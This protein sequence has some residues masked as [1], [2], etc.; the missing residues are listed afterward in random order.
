M[1]LLN[2]SPSASVDTTP[3]KLWYGKRP[4]LSNLKLFGSLAYAKKLKKLG[5]LD[6]R[7]DKLIM[8]MR[9]LGLRYST[10][11]NT[12]LIDA[13]S[14]ADYAGDETSHRST[15]GYVILYMGRPVVAWSTRKQPNISLST[16]ESKFIAATNQC[17]SENTEAERACSRTAN[18]AASGNSGDKPFACPVP[19][20]KKRYKNINGMKYHSKNGHKKDGK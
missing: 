3:A 16:A 15:S 6:K 9:N 5:K 18:S 2:R 10:D 4:D 1:Y 8:G 20:C 17:V 19:G 12:S 11:L 13:Y 14:D 7:C